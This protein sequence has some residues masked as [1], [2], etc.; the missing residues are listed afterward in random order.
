MACDAATT[1]AEKTYRLCLELKKSN[2]AEVISYVKYVKHHRIYYT[3]AKLFEINRR[4][5]LA[6]ATVITNYLI[7]ILQ[8]NG[9]N[10]R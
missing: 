9:I 6:I 10:I 8:L 4:T 5:I 2:D 3:A 1:E 7:V